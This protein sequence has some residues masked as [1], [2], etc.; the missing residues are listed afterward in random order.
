MTYDEIQ[1]IENPQEAQLEK[2]GPLGYCKEREG[3]LILPDV[4]EEFVCRGVSFHVLEL[5]AGNIP[6]V[7]PEAVEDWTSFLHD[8]FDFA[9]Q[10]AA[11]FNIQ[12]ALSLAQNLRELI[13]KPAG[14]VPGTDGLFSVSQRQYHSGQWPVGPGSD[15]QIDLSPSIPVAS[16]FGDI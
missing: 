13:V 9:H 14:L 11:G 16:R 10:T 2:T 8:V 3:L 1:M 4:I 6:N 12:R 5:I 15:T 7:L